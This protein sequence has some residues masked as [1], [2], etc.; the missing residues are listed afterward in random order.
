MIYLKHS[1]NPVMFQFNQIKKINLSVKTD[2]AV[3]L[4]YRQGHW[5]LYVKLNE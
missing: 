4:N 1:N 2:T 5:K 3:T